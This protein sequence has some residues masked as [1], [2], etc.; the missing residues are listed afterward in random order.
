[1]LVTDLLYSKLFF[2]FFLLSKRIRI[3]R[4]N[5]SGPVEGALCFVGGGK[6]YPEPR[7]LKPDV[8]CCLE[9]GVFAINERHDRGYFE[10]LFWLL[11]VLPT[12]NICIYFLNSPN[13]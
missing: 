4:V 3:P 1:M 9:K 7:L 8:F 12:S 2:L 6:H 10:V 13:G 11:S 5:E